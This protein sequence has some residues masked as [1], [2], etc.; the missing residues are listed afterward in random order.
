MIEIS[1]NRKTGSYEAADKIKFKNIMV[2]SSSCDYSDADVLVKGTI[3]VT[4]GG[5]DDAAKQ[6]DE[7]KRM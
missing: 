4:D 1:D 2:K 6:G 3:G 5:V 7:I